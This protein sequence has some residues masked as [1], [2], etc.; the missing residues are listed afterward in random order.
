MPGPNDN[1]LPNSDIP[2]PQPRLKVS[3]LP[4]LSG[5]ISLSLSV[6]IERQDRKRERFNREAG[7]ESGEWEVTGEKG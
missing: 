7:E 2:P 1:P 4:L 6:E 5:D 3:F